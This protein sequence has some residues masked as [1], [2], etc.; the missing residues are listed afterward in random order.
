M[1][2]RQVAEAFSTHHF[3]ATYDRLAPTVRWVSPGHPTL[4]GKDAVVAA[5]EASAAELADLRAVELTRFVSVADERRAAVDVIARYVSHDDTVSLVSSADV[6]E[7]DDAGRVATITS[8]AVELDPA[9][10]PS[11]AGARPGG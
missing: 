9:D 11:G 1:D 4:D 6:Y 10:A 8:Y 7:F 5:C 2:N 3:T